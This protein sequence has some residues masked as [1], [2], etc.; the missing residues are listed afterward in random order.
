MS[1]RAADA[2][3]TH[4]KEENPMNKIKPYLKAVVGFVAPG[5]VV[6]GAAVLPG[7]DGG[8]AITQ[9]ETVTALVAM[10]VTAAGVYTVPNRP[11]TPEDG[12]LPPAP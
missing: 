10:V 3:P 8:T 5:A 7:T 12:E 9:A 1:H 6:F 4:K 11:A 2:A